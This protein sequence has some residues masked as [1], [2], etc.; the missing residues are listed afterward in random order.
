MDASV[1]FGRQ[2]GAQNKE[3]SRFE[4]RTECLPVNLEELR[5]GGVGLVQ[6]RDNRHA[7]RLTDLAENFPS[8]RGS[9]AFTDQFHAMSPVVAHICLDAEKKPPRCT[10]TGAKH[11]RVINF[12]L[13]LRN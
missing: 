9:N 1:G 10:G 13:A 5:K 6:L 12:S 7:Q 8:P 4:R 3:P 11:M 2:P